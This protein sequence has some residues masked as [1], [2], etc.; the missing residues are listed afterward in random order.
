[1]EALNRLPQAVRRRWPWLALVLLSLGLHLWDLG[2]QSFHHDEAIHAR[3]SHNLASDGSYRYDPTYHGPLLYYLTAATFLIAGDSD[4]TARLPIALT[5]VLLIAIAWCLRRPF[6]ERAAWWTGLLVTISPGFLYYGRFLRMD[7]LEVLTASAAMVAVYRGLHGRPRAWVWAGGWAGLAF[8]T[9]ENAYV[10]VALIGLVWA[11]VTAC[12]GLRRLGPTTVGWLKT[13]RWGLLG[14]FSA[15]VAVTVPLYT[16]GFKYPEDWLFPV[17]AIS[18]WADQHAQERVGGP[19]WYHLPRLL[20][21]EFLAIFA[22][23]AWCWRRRRRWRPIEFA[24]LGFALVSVA[25]YCYLGEKVPWL[26]VHQVW[27]FLPL[28]GAQLARTFSH[29]GTFKSQAVAA[30]GLMA[31]LTVTLA[32]TYFNNEISP[33]QRQVESLIYGQTCPDL[34]P[35]IAEG[36]QLAAAGEDPA[37]TVI[38]DSAWPLAWYW[39]NIPVRWIE[40][41]PGSRPPLVLCNSSQEK[42]TMVRLGA[43]YQR[44]RVFLRAWW[45]GH[46]HLPSP[47]ELLRYLFTRVPWVEPSPS[48]VIV[49]RRSDQ[50]PVTAR[51]VPVPAALASPLGAHSARIIGERWLVTPRGIAVSDDGLI[52]VA[53]EGLSQVVFF[54]RQGALQELSIPEPLK[55]PEAVAWTSKGVLVIA[56]TWGQ[57]AV[58]FR[59]TSGGLRALPEPDQGWYGPRGAAAARDGLLAVSNT[60]KKRIVVY[61]PHGTGVEI[62]EIGDPGNGPGQL[63]EPVGLAWLDDGRLV[64]CDTGNRRLQLFDRSGAVSGEVPLPDAWQDFY[65]R[66]QMVIVK[67][68]LWLVTDPPAQALWMVRGDRVSEITLDGMT[69]TGIAWHGDS[70]YLGDG[71]GKLWILECRP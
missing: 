32:A 64:V 34:K 48:D 39:R 57:G 56:D 59:P 20:Q 42:E 61:K 16:V 27:A 50:E 1:M 12:L 71:G 38:G 36:R 19:W 18:Y 68:D 41:E 31:S 69:P 67:P 17:K 2:G 46:E 29:L 66:P 70:L 24:L 47:G 28:A 5:G 45:L 4:F 37:A 33:N 8:A 53:D 40:L 52:A 10:T 62:S 22:A 21:Y 51:D 58:L 14:C 9:K 15:A 13:H 26:I 35:V 49:L 54:D 6:G 55:Q 23:L 44:E 30:V 65:S 25:M 3:N 60:G 7:I 63:V 43:S 11:V